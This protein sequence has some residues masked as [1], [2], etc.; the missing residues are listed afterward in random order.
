MPS[1]QKVEVDEPLRKPADE[2][3]HLLLR[4]T[5]ASNIRELN[6]L[7]RRGSVLFAQGEPA[8]GVYI[9][10]TGRAA[11]S[12]SSSEGRIV[13]LRI[14]QPGD[15]LGVNSVLQNATYDTTVKTL[16]PCRVDF[17][18]RREFI[19]LVGNNTGAVAVMK[20]LSREL[21]ELTDRASSL[22][23]PQKARA[24]L[25]QVLLQCSKEPGG[26]NCRAR[27]IDKVLTHEQIA[28][29]IGSS[30]ETV[31]RLLADLARRQIIGTTS[32]S[33]V[34]RDLAGLEEAA[35]T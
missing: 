31:T 34:I 30:R 7:H 32:D 3:L 19:E 29:M 8:H 9:L 5:H 15:L 24:R 27:V 20:L 2:D 22:L 17:I 25:A 13:I 23:L 1:A 18:P 33:I 14:A 6:S 4:E 11:V 16:E 21:A 12:I 35:R 10:R 28:Q 26:N